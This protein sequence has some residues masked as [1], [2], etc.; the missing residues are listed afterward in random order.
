MPAIGHSSFLQSLGWAVLNS[1]WQMAFLW[2]IYQAIFSINKS[3]KSSQKSLMAAVMLMTGFGWFTYTLLSHWF[4]D[5]SRSTFISNTATGLIANSKINDW[6]QSTL[7]VASVIYLV[8]LLLPVLRFARNYRYV[9]VLRNIGLNKI[10]VEWKIF[11]QRVSAQMGINKPVHIWVSDIITS[12]VT[13]GFLKPI[14]LVPLAA[15]NHLTPQQLEAVLLHELAHIKRQDYL[16]NLLITFIHTILYYNPFVKLFVKTIEKERER[17]C[18]EL[19][20]QFQY[21]PYGYASALLLLEKGNLF[22]QSMAIAASGKKHDLLNRIE[23]ILGVE[24]KSFVS[25]NKIAGIFAGLLC[26]IALNALIILSKPEINKGPFS[27]GNLGNPYYFFAG[28]DD[29]KK[30]ATPVIPAIVKTEKKENPII[31]KAFEIKEPYVAKTSHKKKSG[32]M[33]SAEQNQFTYSFPALAS[34]SPLMNVNLVTEELPALTQGQEEQVQ[35]ALDATKI[36]LEKAQWKQ[37]EHNAADALTVIEKGKLKDFYL[38]ELNGVNWNKM[39]DRLR[40]SYNNINWN[41]INDQLNN[42]IVDY[43]LD[44]LQTAYTNLINTLNK[45]E[46]FVVAN[47]FQETI[48]PDMCIQT[49]R[50]RKCEATKNLTRIKAIRAKKIVHL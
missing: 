21:D 16:I 11:V 33:S 41:K 47:Q 15:I 34:S 45:A 39:A 29:T 37:I 42:V 24:K 49:I 27:F 48:S 20:M 46:H 19:V 44:S 40:Q 6:L 30:E 17:S 9:Q 32:K 50:E 4:I 13:I 28:D 23:R 18:D 26:I 35:E 31:T 8:L 14:I 7:P 12:P 25:F 1:L 10:H 5:A 22:I 38:K 2:V 36:V 43:K 3:A